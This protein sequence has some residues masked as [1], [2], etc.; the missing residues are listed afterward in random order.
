MP[1]DSVN[2]RPQ[3]PKPPRLAEKTLAFLLDQED[4]EVI[5][6]D[7]EEAFM[8]IARKFSVEQARRWYWIELVKSTP[9]LFFLAYNRS[10]R[11]RIMMKGNPTLAFLS[12]ALL[13]PAFLLVSG[14][15]AQSG[16]GITKINDVLNFD[17]V[18]FHPAVIVGGLMLALAINLFPIVRVNYQDGVL[19][20]SLMIRDRLLNVGLISCIGLC[21]GIIFLYLLAENFQLFQLFF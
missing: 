5:L 15:L 17:L 12:A 20:G 9:P 6:G 21:A 4:K 13:L 3:K 8:V 14:G 18:F 2:P 7:F 19:T 10:T 11:S 16:L 1:V